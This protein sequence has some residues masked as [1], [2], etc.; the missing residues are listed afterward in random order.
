MKTISRDPKTI[1]S[2]ITVNYHKKGKGSFVSVTVRSFCE[3]TLEEIVGCLQ[4]ASHT[5]LNQRN[6]TIQRKEVKHGKKKVK[7]TNRRSKNRYWHFGK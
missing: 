4:E 1:V 6:I 3:L 2:T 5:L 7:K